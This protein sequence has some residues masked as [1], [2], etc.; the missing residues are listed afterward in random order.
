MQSFDISQGIVSEEITDLK[1]Q[2]KFEPGKAFSRSKALL[3][4]HF[5]KYL[6]CNSNFGAFTADELRYDAILLNAVVK[7]LMME[8]Y[9]CTIVLNADPVASAMLQA[10]REQQDKLE[11]D[12]LNAA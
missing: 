10:A 1:R 9:Q 11:K 4:S 3:S 12:N 6:D 7:G 5:K 2:V 8:A